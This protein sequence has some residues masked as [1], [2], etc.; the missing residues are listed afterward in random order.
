LARLFQNTDENK[1]LKESEMGQYSC[2]KLLKAMEVV[3]SKS[4]EEDLKIVE[5]VMNWSGCLGAG[6]K[7]METRGNFGLPKNLYELPEIPG[8]NEAVQECKDVQMEDKKEQRGAKKKWGPILVEQRPSRQLKDGRI[9]LEKAQKR[10]KFTNLDGYH[11][12][13]KTYNPFSILSNSEISNVAKTVSVEI[14]KDKSER[15]SSLAK[16]QELDLKRCNTPCYGEP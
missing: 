3:M 10:K 6:W 16:I 9:V 13:S 2:T 15:A 8:Q 14:E 1:S 7:I 5:G 11:G 12:N 4:D